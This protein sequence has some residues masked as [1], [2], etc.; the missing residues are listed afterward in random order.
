MRINHNPFQLFSARFHETD[1]L[2]A[3]LRGPANGAGFRVGL[4]QISCN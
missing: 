4:L 3:V 1:A 2:P